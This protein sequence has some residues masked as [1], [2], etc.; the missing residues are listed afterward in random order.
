M[1]LFDHCFQCG[2]TVDT[3]DGGEGSVRDR[4]GHWFCTIRCKE[5]YMRRFY[6]I[7][8]HLREMRKEVRGN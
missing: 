7:D 8:V 1:K 2:A 3:T 6:E 5:D 4:V